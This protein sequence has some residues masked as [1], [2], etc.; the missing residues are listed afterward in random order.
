LEKLAD[1]YVHVFGCAPVYPERHLSGNWIEIGTRVP[2]VKID[3]THLRLPGYGDNGPTIE[4]FQYNKYKPISK[5]QI[6]RQGLAH[7]AFFVDNVN[8]MLEKVLE[9]GGGQL[10]D[11]VQ[12]E[13]PGV[14]FLTFVYASDP[15]GNFIELQNYNFDAHK[16]E[17][18]RKTDI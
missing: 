2:N 10:G 14:G 1:F 6:N 8:D 18:T 9:F 15:E 12:K 11:V 16:N 4:I 7:L 13:I 3:G 5:Q 17:S